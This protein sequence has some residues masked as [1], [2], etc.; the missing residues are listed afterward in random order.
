[1]A[2]KAAISALSA[3]LDAFFER[4]FVEDKPTALAVGIVLNGELVY[5]HMFGVRDRASR[6]PIDGD[7]VFR[8]ASLTKSFTALAVLRLRDEGRLELDA[9]LTRY[10][11]EVAE[12]KPPVYDAAPLTARMLLTHTGGLPNDNMWAPVSLGFGVTD[13]DRL[14]RSR[15]TLPLVPGDDYEYSNLGYQRMTETW[16]PVDAW[17]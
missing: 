2:E 16:T 6:Q 4:R 13:L 11:P 9:P 5:E 7:T 17:S 1:M 14:L 8:I 15:I 10:L 12:L 3:E